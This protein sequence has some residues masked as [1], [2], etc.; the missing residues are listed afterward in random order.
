MTRQS[1]AALLRCCNVVFSGTLRSHSA[2]G[3][4][5]FQFEEAND[6][7]QTTHYRAYSA[8]ETNYDEF[9]PE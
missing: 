7:I 1:T 4:L 6:S 5:V 2:L 3:A 8:S 9:P